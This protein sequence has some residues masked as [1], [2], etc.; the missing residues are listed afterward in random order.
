MSSLRSQGEE[1]PDTAT[2]MASTNSNTQQCQQATHLATL[3][4]EEDELPTEEAI[5]LKKHRQ[6]VQELLGENEDGSPDHKRLMDLIKKSRGID[7]LRPPRTS[8][9]MKIRYNE[10]VFQRYR[11]QAARNPRS[12]LGRGPLTGSPE[13]SG[14][15]YNIV[16]S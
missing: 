15:S 14:R 7:N 12:L 11:S 1:R 16:G 13:A 3:G 2:S 4:R 6:S 8:L 9:D 10:A 5:A